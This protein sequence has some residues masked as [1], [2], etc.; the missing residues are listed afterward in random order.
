MS[1]S[2]DNQAVRAPR[3]AANYVILSA[4]EFIAKVFGA[5]AFAYLARVLGPQRY[6]YLEFAIAIIFFFT[7]NLWLLVPIHWGIEV[8]CHRLLAS[9]SQRNNGQQDLS[10]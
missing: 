2:L 5:V 7:R 4:G 1:Q 10:D 9:F 6:G 8:A 3:L